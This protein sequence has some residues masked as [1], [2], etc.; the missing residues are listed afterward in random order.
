MLGRGNGKGR[1]KGAVLRGHP[2]LRNRAQGCRDDEIKGTGAFG[3]RLDV[4]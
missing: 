3:E 2:I 4:P 1:S